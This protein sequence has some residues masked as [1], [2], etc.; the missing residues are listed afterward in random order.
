[1]T[2]ACFKP[3]ISVGSTLTRVRFYYLDNPVHLLVSCTGVVKSVIT[4]PCI[5][6]HMQQQQH[7]PVEFTQQRDA[8]PQL[9]SYLGMSLHK[10][11]KSPEA[12]QSSLCDRDK[13]CQLFEQHLKL[14]QML[15][16]R[17]GQL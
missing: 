3:A 13:L 12:I 16:E 6:F 14:M 11:F 1:M 17:L 7:Q 9:Q 4:I 2:I 5:S 15:Q 10:Y 8:Q